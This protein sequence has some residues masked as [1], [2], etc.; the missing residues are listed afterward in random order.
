M[1]GIQETRTQQVGGGSWETPSEEKEREEDQRSQGSCK[2]VSDT[3][4][5][6]KV[7]GN[8]LEFVNCYCYNSLNLRFLLCTSVEIASTES[9]EF[10]A[11]QECNKNRAEW[12][13]IKEN[14]QTNCI[15]TTNTS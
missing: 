7:L 2:V 5:S 12:N 6:K 4:E 1:G 13:T 3:S 10:M 9:A 14:H 11:I 15:P 8:N